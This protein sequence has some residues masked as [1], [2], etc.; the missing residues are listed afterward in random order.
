MGLD[1]RIQSTRIFVVVVRNPVT[2]PCIRSLLAKP[3]TKSESTAF[4]FLLASSSS[5][6]R[7]EVGNRGPEAHQAG[8]PRGGRA[9]SGGSR[10]AGSHRGS[11]GE[12][13]AARL[14][15][16]CRGYMGGWNHDIPPRPGAPG[17]PGAGGK[18]PGGN[19]GGG[20]AP[21]TP[22]A[23]PYFETRVSHPVSSTN[24]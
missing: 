15:G 21:P 18:P 1:S 5:P 7:G 12:G 2:R 13:G 16:W 23:G 9:R 11:L 17:N 24:P 20:A 19:P 3:S 6:P 8:S 10:R 4:A 22:A 14:L